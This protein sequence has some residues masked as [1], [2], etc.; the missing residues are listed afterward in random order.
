MTSV[1]QKLVN[2]ITCLMAHACNLNNKNL[3]FFAFILCLGYS[4]DMK[5]K[6]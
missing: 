6:Q 1:N 2:D 4:V 5:E 3:S